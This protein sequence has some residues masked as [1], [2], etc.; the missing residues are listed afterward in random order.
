VK[1]HVLLEPPEAW[2]QGALAV[3]C[4]GHHCPPDDPTACRWCVV[5]ALKKC[6]GPDSFLI[7]EPL[8]A[9]LEQNRALVLESLS[10]HNIVAYWNDSPERTH[11]DVVALLKKLDL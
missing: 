2:V 11:A 4:D 5:G 1:A 10:Y 6:Y 3:D 8:K 7:I 9:D